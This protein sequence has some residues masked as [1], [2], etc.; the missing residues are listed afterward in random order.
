MGAGLKH[1]F[2]TFFHCHRLKLYLLCCNRS[3]QGHVHIKM[4]IDKGRLVWTAIFALEMLITL[5]GNAIAIAVFWKQRSTLKRNCYLLINLAVADLLVGIGEIVHL[6]NNIFFYVKN[7]K[8]A[9]WENI[10]LLPDAFAGS[11]S[12][13]FL[14]VISV[15]RLYAIAR[16]FHHRA[17][18][19][20]VYFYLIAVTWILATAIT[21]IFLCSLILEII[22]LIIPMLS[23][24]SALGFCL[25]VILCSYFAIWKFK[26]NEVPGMPKDRRQQNKK[27]ALTLSIVTFLSVLTW[28][29][30]IVDIV[31]IIAVPEMGGVKN[32][33]YNIGRSLQLA[34][35]SINPIVY[36]ARMPEFRKQLRNIILKQKS[37]KEQRGRQ[38]ST[39]AGDVSVPVL[40]SVST[41]NRTF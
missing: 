9:I 31:I 7:S 10:V 23:S 33:L 19:T 28:L 1:F 22:N 25:V 39:M 37:H 13:L 21:S 34:N 6:F 20:R 24:A 2:T 16:P 41:L 32:S 18:N 30:F 40:L 8:S 4:G 3:Q 17:T 5:I 14:T 38:L 27:L 36:Y 15:E 12:L 29:P 11:A 26:R 35:S